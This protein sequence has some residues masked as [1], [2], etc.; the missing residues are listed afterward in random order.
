MITEVKVV[1]KVEKIKHVCASESYTKQLKTR[2]TFSSLGRR[3]D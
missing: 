3:R 2:G 1:E